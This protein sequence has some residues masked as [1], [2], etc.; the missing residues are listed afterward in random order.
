[1]FCN[2]FNRLSCMVRQRKFA[3]Y[4]RLV[5]TMPAAAAARWCQVYGHHGHERSLHQEGTH[6]WAAVRHIQGWLMYCS[7]HAGWSSILAAHALA[8]TLGSGEHLLDMHMDS[9]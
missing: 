7:G 4:C 9:A 8:S 1:M 3:T 6:R 2:S 5:V